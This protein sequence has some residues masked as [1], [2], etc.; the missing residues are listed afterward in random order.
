[1]STQLLDLLVQE[2]QVQE[3]TIDLALVEDV[4][5]CLALEAEAVEEK[6][7]QYESHYWTPQFR[8]AE[9]RK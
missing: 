8:T 4:V 5:V 2:A 9:R 1:M 3:I 7:E 6:W